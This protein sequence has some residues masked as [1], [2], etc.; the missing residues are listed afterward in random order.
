VRKVLKETGFV[1][2]A[3]LSDYFSGTG[4]HYWIMKKAEQ[5]AALDGNSA[6]LHSGR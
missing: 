3:D 2:E 4:L 5:G 6:A 1:L